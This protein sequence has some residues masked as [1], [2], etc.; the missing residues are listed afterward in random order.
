MAGITTAVVLL[1][2]CAGTIDGRTHRIPDWLTL[3]LVTAGIVA[4]ALLVPADLLPNILAAILGFL[5]FY[6]IARLY[7]SLRGYDGLGLGD[8]K[9][10]AAAG[11][12]LGPLYLAPVVF[13][14]AI[15][16][17]GAALILRLLGR[18]VSLQTT[19]PFGPFLSVSFFG[20]WCLKISGWSLFS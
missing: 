13:V 14:S 18:E 9:L 17:I 15:L 20:F 10:L 19:L 6:L 8:A 16:A 11:A 2:F 4:T 3:I 1:L 5:S 12:W 7:R